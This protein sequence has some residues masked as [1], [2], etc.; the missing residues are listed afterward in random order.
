MSDNIHIWKQNLHNSFTNIV[1]VTSM[2]TS[3]TANTQQICF[4]I[5]ESKQPNESS[6]Y[7]INISH[8]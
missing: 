3:Q 8:K 1:S 2:V 4:D 7:I 6:N 5:P